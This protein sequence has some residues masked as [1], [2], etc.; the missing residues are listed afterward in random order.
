[1]KEMKI[2]K[3]AMMDETFSVVGVGCWAIGGDWNNITDQSSI[4]AV[5]RAVDLGINLFD[6]APVYGFGHA[7]EVLGKALKGGRQKVL[8]AS[9]CG[10]LWD[11]QKNVT[12]NLTAKSVLREIDDSLRRL[13]TDYIDIYQLH[14]PD[15]NT[16]I[17]ET[18]EALD[19]IKESGKIRYIGVSNFSV[20]LTKQ[21][22]QVGT[23]VSHQG[24]YNM[25]E[26]N[27]ESYH[28]IPLTY[29]TQEEILPFCQEH[30]LAFF[31]YSPLFQ[32]LLA[33]TF[34]ISGNF[35][36]NDM[37]ASNPKLKGDRLQVYLEMVEKLKVFAQ[38]IGKPLSQ[39]AINWLIKQDAVTSVLCGVRNIQHVEGNVAS[40]EWELT[41]EIMTQIEKILA[42]YQL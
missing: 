2:K 1:V 28:E 24:L 32:G 8:I 7:E 10:L 30:G 23:V 26:R 33:G 11:E 9:K 38:E 31:P 27:P 36:D 25:L 5:Q 16:P 41:D 13:D 39:I 42:P 4:E 34:K 40:V 35:D 18:M 17:E 19:S 20:E 21:A 29:R 14:W 22:M 3:V 6:V 37:R 12:N 15:P